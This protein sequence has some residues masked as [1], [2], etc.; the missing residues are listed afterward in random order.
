MLSQP[1][2]HSMA[3]HGTAHLLRDGDS[4]SVPASRDTDAPL[5]SLRQPSPSWL[6]S[7][8]AK[9]WIIARDFS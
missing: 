8:K 5:L 4:A 7:V 3:Q 9:L 2:Q 1:A 6:L